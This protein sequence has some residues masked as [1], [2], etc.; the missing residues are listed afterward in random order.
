MISGLLTNSGLD[1]TVIKVILESM[2]KELHVRNNIDL[3]IFA[4]LV[5]AASYRMSH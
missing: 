4:P 1:E 5:I 2:I 3:T